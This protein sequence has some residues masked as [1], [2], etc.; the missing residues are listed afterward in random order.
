MVVFALL[1]LWFVWRER[2]RHL[3][4]FLSLPVIGATGL[5][6]YNMQLGGL[7]R[8]GYGRLVFRLPTWSAFTG[9]LVS[10]NRGLF[11]Y[12][13]AA[14]LALPAMWRWAGVAPWVRYLPVGIVA[15]LILYSSWIGW[16]GGNTY[17]PRFLT[18][19][20]P[21][22][23][24]CAV[25]VVE[26]LCRST[27]GRALVLVLVAWGVVVQAVG[28]YWDDNAWNNDRAAGDRLHQYIWRW[29]D[30]QIQR[31]ASAGWHGSELGPLLWQAL[32][33]PRPARL[34]ELSGAQLV[35]EIVALTPGPYRFAAGERVT[36][37]VRV[38]NRGD[39]TWPAFSDYGYLQCKL[40]YRWWQ[41]GQVR[42]ESGA[43][44]LPRNV[45][46]GESVGVAARLMTPAQPGDYELELTLIQVLGA[47]KG[48]AGPMLRAGVSVE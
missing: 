14:V 34:V 40:A 37:E 27:A 10:P 47:D 32:T 35:G 3:L 43:V 6:L 19:V 33:D 17:G 20:L 1:A 26:R 9:L 11:V 30:W 5:I 18:D 12:T 21:A 48:I 13:P 2:R 7:I 23:V 15:Y 46:P 25:P 31:A 41:H 36:V 24:L 42:L 8:G 38:T 22:L 39:T 44:P 28:V 45:A 29:D 4:A 16:W